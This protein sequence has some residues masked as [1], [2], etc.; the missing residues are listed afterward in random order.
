MSSNSNNTESKT[1]INPCPNV[2]LL[3]CADGTPLKMREHCRCHCGPDR[4]TQE[5][6]DFDTHLNVLEIQE[7]LRYNDIV[8]TWDPKTEPWTG[9]WIGRRRRNKHSNRSPR[10]RE[11]RNNR[12]KRSRKIQ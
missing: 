4:R 5:E 1:P 7:Y 6:F 9:G 8:M 10:H 12:R 2:R 11:L 3:R